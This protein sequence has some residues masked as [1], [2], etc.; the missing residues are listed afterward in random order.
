MSVPSLLK[1]VFDKCHEGW[2]VY[3]KV[4]SEYKSDFVTQMYELLEVCREIPV[5][6]F[7]Q[8]MYVAYTDNY[9]TSTGH[10]KRIF[11]KEDVVTIEMTDGKEVAMEELYTEEFGV[12]LDMVECYFDIKK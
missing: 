6:D 2:G 7:E 8:R 3:S 9:Q 5:P 12:I 4:E 11:L 1:P 10:M